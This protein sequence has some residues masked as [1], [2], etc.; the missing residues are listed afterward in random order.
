MKVCVAEQRYCTRCPK[1]NSESK[2]KIKKAIGKDFV[3]RLIFFSKTNN[4]R[5]KLEG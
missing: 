3:T 5:K 4:T 1:P 2:L